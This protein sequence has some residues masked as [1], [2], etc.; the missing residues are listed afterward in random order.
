LPTA[1]FGSRQTKRATSSH[2]D[3]L[4][5]AECH[6]DRVKPLPTAFHV[7]GGKGFFADEFF[8]TSS[9]PT[10]SWKAV[11]NAFADYFRAFVG[12]LWQSAK[13]SIPIV[14]RGF[15]DD[16]LK[17]GPTYQLFVLSLLFLFHFLY[18]SSQFS[19]LSFSILHTI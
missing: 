13:R 1:T 15:A 6:V 11:G 4:S 17:V 8:A 19:I 14:V 3:V 2:D 10:A 18:S 7:V 5:F 9:L 16:A 12:Y